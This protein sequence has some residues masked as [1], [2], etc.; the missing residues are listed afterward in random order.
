MLNTMRTLSGYRV[1]LA[2]ALIPWLALTAYGTAVAGIGSSGTLLPGPF[3]S[4]DN[5]GVLEFR[6]GAMFNEVPFFV[7]PS[8]PG[9]NWVTQFTLEIPN[10]FSLPN[11]TDILFFESLTLEDHSSGPSFT[12]PLAGWA[13]TLTVDTGQLSGFSGNLAFKT[14]SDPGFVL[15]NDYGVLT[16]LGVNF[17]LSPLTANSVEFLFSQ[18][19]TPAAVP[20]NSYLDLTTT[21]I[22]TGST[23]TASGSPITFPNL[24]T[25]TQ[26]P[27]VVPE[28]SSWGLGTGL[29]AFA[30]LFLSRRRGEPQNK[31]S[32]SESEWRL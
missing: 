15:N 25:I 32:P 30:V 6:V 4:A 11:D 10:G 24:I 19:L 27:T 14:P 23:I 1:I 18:E 2:L 21:L 26:N 12:V 3:T 31:S 16:D 8:M 22:Y 5:G 9:T 20:A 7:D 17:S 29:M 28:T 13:Q